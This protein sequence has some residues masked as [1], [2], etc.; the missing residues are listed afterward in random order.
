MIIGGL[1]CILPMCDFRAVPCPPHPRGLTA[2]CP[3]PK[4]APRPGIKIWEEAENRPWALSFSMEGASWQSPQTLC[5][6]WLRGE[7]GDGAGD[8]LRLPSLSFLICK[9]GLM[10][11]NER[12][13]WGAC[14]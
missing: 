10:T 5:Q 14:N 8:V 1:I 3:T 12:G 11:L 2:V 13:G 9:L 7:G 6:L 4:P